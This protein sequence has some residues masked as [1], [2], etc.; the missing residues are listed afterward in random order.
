MIAYRRR[1]GGFTMIEMV[2]SIGIIVVLLGI[3]LPVLR[4]SIESA[5]RTVCYSN[6]HTF[7][8]AI[9]MFRDDHDGVM[10]YSFGG[11]INLDTN[12]RG[13]IDDLAPYIDGVD[14]PRM[15]SDGRMIVVAPYRCPSDDEV[16]DYF[17]MSYTYLLGEFIMLNR[18]YSGDTG[19]E[20]ERR[21]RAKETAGWL[22]E[23]TPERARSQVMADAGHWHPQVGGDP[24]TRR[25][26]LRFDGSIGPLTTND[27]HR[28]V[29]S[30]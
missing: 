14:P 6:L 1:V 18:E 4:G 12:A 29:N 19:D 3:T 26:T 13:P 5:R 22:Y 16:A 10:P 27:E 24:A 7:G 11:F 9:R 15:E 28:A 30:R 23:S 21:R 20:R 2:V 25:N 17:G 8:Q